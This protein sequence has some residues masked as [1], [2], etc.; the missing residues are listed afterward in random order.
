MVSWLCLCLPARKQHS[1]TDRP[2]KK[3]GKLNQRAPFSLTALVSQS[4]SGPA[5]RVSPLFRAGREE[6]AEEESTTSCVRQLVD[7]E[8]LFTMH[9][10]TQLAT[11]SHPA[12]TQCN[13]GSSHLATEINADAATDGAEASVI[14]NERQQTAWKFPTA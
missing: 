1:R 8:A 2:R 14:F 7:G 12:L 5:R 9:A 4:L 3:N 10:V 11:S 6:A 13:T